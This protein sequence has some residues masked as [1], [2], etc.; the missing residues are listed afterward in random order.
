MVSNLYRYEGNNLLILPS[1]K[2][3]SAT[4]QSRLP[5]ILG[6]VVGAVVLC[7]AIS[8]VILCIM[9]RKRKTH[10]I[11]TSSNE[12]AAQNTENPSPYHVN[13]AIA[14]RISEADRH[15]ENPENHSHE[16]CNPKI[17]HMDVKSSN[18]LIT[19]NLEGKMSDF[20]ISRL[21]SSEGG[22]Q[23][24]TKLVGSSGYVDPE[25]VLQS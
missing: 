7:V 3:E 24:T 6:V 21:N 19:E 17:I 15:G 4:K 2:T 13:Q 20:G 8:I 5:L 1:N 18:I 23:V 22:I 16:S 25:Y 12:L 11:P 10:E 14:T 9:C